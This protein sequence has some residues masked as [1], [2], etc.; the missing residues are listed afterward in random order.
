MKNYLKIYLVPLVFVL[1]SLGGC[2]KWLDEIVPKDKVPSSQLFSDPGGIKTFMAN[3]YYNAPIEDF[4]YVVNGFNDWRATSWNNSR[5]TEEGPHKNGAS[6]MGGGDLK[7]FADG[8]TEIRNINLLIENIPT[9]N[10]QKND[11]TLYLGESYFLLAY[12]YYALVKRCGGVPLITKVQEYDPNNLDALKV[13]RSTEKE[14]WN[15]TLA[16]CDS[17]IKYLPVVHPLGARR[18]G[19]YVAYALKSRVALHAASVAKFWE[20]GAPGSSTDPAI[21][22]KLVGGMNMDDAN[23]YYK[24]CL[25]AS[26]FL[27]NSKAFSLYLPIPTSP[28]EAAANLQKMFADPNVAPMELIFIKGYTTVGQGHSYQVM[29]PYQIG[30]SNSIATHNPTLDF[31]EF[32]E[33]YSDDGKGN[34]VKLAT[35]KSGNE[36]I[37]VDFNKATDYIHY[38]NPMDIFNGNG[39]VG[40]TSN[41]SKRMDARLF[42]SILLPGSIWKGLVMNFQ[43]G[44]IKTDGT[45]VEGANF[46]PVVKNGV[47]YYA[48]G[49]AST[50][51]CSGWSLPSNSGTRTGFLPKKFM[52]E[53]GIIDRTKWA[54]SVND[55]PEFRYAEILL[56]YA[57]AVVENTAGYGDQSVA[58]DAINVIR[59]RAGH[60]DKVVATKN[61]TTATA[62]TSLGSVQ[63][64]RTVELA[65]ENKRH[66]DLLRRREYH[67]V[68]NVR[69]YGALKLY[70]DLRTDPVSYFYVRTYSPLATNGLTFVKSNYYRPID[71][72][73]SNGLVQNP[74]Y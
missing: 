55:W 28:D 16:L 58:N 12:T 33:D 66:W 61:T 43:G 29:V 32:Y 59:R 64:E 60:T 4:N 65:Y 27:M 17:A 35:L 20:E 31:V 6:I 19:G 22:Q 42:S 57:E 50:S 2:T 45:N 37:Y 9:A 7:Y 71:G 23:N 10:L 18:A 11:K 1:L 36:N 72:V 47:N 70:Q 38:A 15:F 39:A 46:T 3:L 69:K 63:R 30:N 21:Q 44:L 26:L 56:N 51:L 40:S 24:Q 62:I 73:A 49:G 34:M 8:Y 53:N 68:Y 74:G 54:S 25:D 41:K 5:L 14:T 48:L 13:P 67:K 52:D